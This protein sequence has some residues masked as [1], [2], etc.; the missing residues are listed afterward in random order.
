[1][2]VFEGSFS[3]KEWKVVGCLLDS[4]RILLLLAKLALM[5]SKEGY[6]GT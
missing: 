2:V 1:M 5:E 3:E 4:M 6:G